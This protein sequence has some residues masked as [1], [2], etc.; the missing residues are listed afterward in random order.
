MVGSGDKHDEVRILIVDDEEAILRVF[1]TIISASLSNVHIVLARNGAEAVASFYEYHPRIILLDL[2]MP[3]MDGLT[4]FQKIAEICRTQN[5]KMPY[6]I[7]CTGYAPDEAV[8]AIVANSSECCLI[9]KPVSPDKII[10][11]IKSKLNSC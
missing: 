2:H 5:L 8:K 3:V 4:A 9:K 6:V 1:K 7:F 11:T 10:E